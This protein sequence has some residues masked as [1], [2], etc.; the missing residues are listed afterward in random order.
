M[1]EESDALGG[2]LDNPTLMLMQ[3]GISVFLAYL[4]EKQPILPNPS[5]FILQKAFM[6]W[7]GGFCPHDKTPPPTETIY[8]THI[9][10][11]YKQKE[12]S[13]SASNFIL[14]FALPSYYTAL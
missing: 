6:A 13:D 3:T 12:S 9:L 2:N 5:T 11:I 8:I 10:C 7:G 4:Q 1:W 14:Y